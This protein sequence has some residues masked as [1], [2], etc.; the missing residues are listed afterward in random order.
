MHRWAGSA[1]I[2]NVLDID[3]TLRAI[4]AAE[5]DVDYAAGEKELSELLVRFPNNQS[6]TWRRAFFLSQLG[7][8]EEALVRIVVPIT[9]NEEDAFR[10]AAAAA[11]KA[12]PDGHTLFFTYGGVLTTGLPLFRKLAYDPMKDF[13]PIGL[14]AVGQL[15]LVDVN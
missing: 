9:T 1:N 5:G 6:L 14:V 12:N 8:T 4:G 2:V 3:C 11:A 10:I 13:S 15:A 7:R